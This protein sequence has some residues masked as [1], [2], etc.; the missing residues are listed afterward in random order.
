MTTMKVNAKGTKKY[1]IKRKLK[2]EDYKNCIKA[3]ELENK[4]Y[5]LERNKV[6]ADSL[7]KDHKEFMKNNKLILKS[8][9]RFRSG[10]Q[11]IYWGS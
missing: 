7:K 1:V 9:Q 3:T 4:V 2:F 11:C 8:R 5:Q 10:N 6:N